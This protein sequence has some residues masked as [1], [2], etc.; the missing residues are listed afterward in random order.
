MHRDSMRSKLNTFSG[1][2]QALYTICFASVEVYKSFVKQKILKKP[3]PILKTCFDCF[4][5]R[6]T[7]RR[8]LLPLLPF[9]RNIKAVGSREWTALESSFDFWPSK[10]QEFYPVGLNQ[11]RVMK[12]LRFVGARYPI[13]SFKLIKHAVRD[14]IKPVDLFKA[15]KRNSYRYLRFN[16]IETLSL[17]SCRQIFF[18]DGL[19]AKSSKSILRVECTLHHN[20]ID[21]G[22][23]RIG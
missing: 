21:F 3:S 5:K 11:R 6:R 17:Q 10:V 22:E 15:A 14:Q 9:N 18:I 7:S 20:S 1:Y 23:L 2:W 19:F 13:Y 8:N 16:F 12:C 4:C